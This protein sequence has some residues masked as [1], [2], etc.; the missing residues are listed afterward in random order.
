[1]NSGRKNKRCRV[2]HYITYIRYANYQRKDNF[3]E[4]KTAEVRKVG[5]NGSKCLLLAR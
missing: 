5:E 3:I 1:M 2:K 4:K